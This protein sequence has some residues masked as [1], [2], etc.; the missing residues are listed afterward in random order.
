MVLPGVWNSPRRTSVAN[1]LPGVFINPWKSATYRGFTK[2]LVLLG[3]FG[4]PATAWGFWNPHYCLGFLKPLFL[5]RVF[6][7][8]LQP[9]VFETP[10]TAWGLKPPLLSYLGLKLLLLLMVQ[11]PIC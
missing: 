6:E 4:T 9:G 7:P 5:L 11:I 1:R 8:L 3:V 2:P 10:A